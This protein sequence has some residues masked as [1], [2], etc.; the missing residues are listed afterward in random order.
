MR[1]SK[2]GERR[3]R[4]EVDKEVEKGEEEVGDKEGKEEER[5]PGSQHLPICL[6]KGKHE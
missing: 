5:R 2:A 3:K 4:K 6:S 1:R